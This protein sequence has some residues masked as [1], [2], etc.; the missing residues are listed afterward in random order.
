M[1]IAPIAGIFVMLQ[2]ASAGAADDLSLERMAT[3]RDSWFDWSKSDPGQLQ[4]FGD[5][6]RSQFSPNQNGAFFVPKTGISIAGLRVA[7]AFPNSIGMGVGFSVLVDATFDETRRISEKILGRSLEKCETG[8]NM[9]TCSL[10]IGPKRTFTLMAE[11]NP[12]SATTLLGC[13]YFYEK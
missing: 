11:D 5:H 3:C 8:D 4:K 13:Y 6:F 1:R 7:Q 10:E 12:K 2:I 9:R